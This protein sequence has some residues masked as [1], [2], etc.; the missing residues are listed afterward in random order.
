MIYHYIV[1]L[2]NSCYELELGE[3]LNIQSQN[4]IVL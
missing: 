1:L 2:V 3:Q 4:L